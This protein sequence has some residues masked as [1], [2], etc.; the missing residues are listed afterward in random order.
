[1]SL[2]NHPEHYNIEGR[3]ECIEEMLENYGKMIT[4]CFCLTNAYKYLYRAGYKEGNSA[5]QDVEK[6]KWYFD[7]AKNRC[8]A[9]IKI[10][11][12]GD[13]FRSTS[14]IEKELEKYD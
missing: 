7:Y 9:L 6:A 11:R 1:M 2:V 10:H 3:K 8:S 14:F 12:G 13:L 4:G 5:E